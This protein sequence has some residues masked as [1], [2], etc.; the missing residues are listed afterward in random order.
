MFCCS[1]C[2]EFA[3]FDLHWEL[4]QWP[5]NLFGL[6]KTRRTGTKQITSCQYWKWKFCTCAVTQIWNTNV[7]FLSLSVLGLCSKENR[8][9]QAKQIWKKP[10]IAQILESPVLMWACSWQTH[11]QSIQLTHDTDHVMHHVV[12]S[13]CVFQS[14]KR[15]NEMWSQ[16]P[17]RLCQKYSW[18]VS[19]K[20][21]LFLLQGWVVSS[22]W[23]NVTPSDHKRK[24]WVSIT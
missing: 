21:A 19:S 12:Q 8:G 15:E 10:G 1:L 20:N 14:R 3:M 2:F 22:C 18:C 6:W 16:F 4:S 24:C 9:F 11:C 13:H 7:Y 23:Q 17:W 5:I